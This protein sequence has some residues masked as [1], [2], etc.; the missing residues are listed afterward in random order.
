MTERSL[1]VTGAGGFLGSHICQY[2]GA[3]GHKIAALGRFASDDSLDAMYPNL[4][5]LAG[6]TLPD[7]AFIKAVRHF[8]PD[9]V[10]HCA[11][12]AS[13]AA[14]VQRPY[15]DFQSTVEV[16]AFVLNTLHD[17]APGC[18][19]ILLS[20]AAVY[21]EPSTLP[22]S[23]STPCDPISPYGYHKWLCELLV[24]E[25]R[26]LFNM[27]ASSLRIFSAYGER[28]QRLVADVGHGVDPFGQHRRRAGRR[29]RRELRDHHERVRRDGYVDSLGGSVGH[30]NREPLRGGARRPPRWGRGRRLC[31]GP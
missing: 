6:M 26:S 2:F 25:Y 23:E 24:R 10:V 4:R 8:R 28:Q 7:P 30:A 27:N 13:V 3:R 22:V 1:L 5:L 9:L 18:K 19:F 31:S 11:G 20:S 29:E 15:T 17:H 21:G 12:T 16:C 14:S